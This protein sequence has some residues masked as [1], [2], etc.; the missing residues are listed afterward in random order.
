MDYD[1][2]VQYYAT[3]QPN[4]SESTA[5]FN[6]EQSPPI[7]TVDEIIVLDSYDEE[8]QRP[9]QIK[10]SSSTDDSDVEIVSQSFR[11]TDPLISA[12]VDQPSTSTRDLLNIPNNSSQSVYGGLSRVSCSSQVKRSWHNLDSSSDDE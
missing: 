3:H 1:R 4:D 9:I 7:H 8:P 5:P 2:N 6:Q 10:D 12:S 11:S